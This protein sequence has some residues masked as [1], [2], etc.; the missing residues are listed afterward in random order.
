MLEYGDSGAVSAKSDVLDRHSP[1]GETDGQRC[2]IVVP[3]KRGIGTALN[4]ESSSQAASTW[5][6]ER[7]GSIGKTCRHPRISP[8]LASESLP[9]TPRHERIKAIIARRKIVV[10]PDEAGGG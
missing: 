10:S 7:L 6:R 2:R 9:T 4:V 8:N 5:A 1:A 3:L